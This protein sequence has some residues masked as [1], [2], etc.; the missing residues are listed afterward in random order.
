MIRGI[1]AGLIGLLAAVWHAPARAQ[2]CNT[3]CSMYQEG[4]CVEHTTTCTTPP[5]PPPAYGAIAYGKKSG[6]WGYSYHWDSRA[7]AESV[8]MENC[9]KNGNDC[10]V[11]VWFQR[12][13]GAVAAPADA[14]AAY[15]GLGDGEGAAR[16]EAMRQ[17]TKDGGK[18]CEVK[19]SQCSR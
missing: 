9:S 18:G 19:V 1:A 7:K 15:W 16:E 13:C 14:G 2:V 11:M 10:E 12:E 6:A 5:P 4:E 3:T 17:C 8:A